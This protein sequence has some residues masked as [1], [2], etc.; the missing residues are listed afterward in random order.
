METI[1]SLREGCKIS[2]DAEF[3]LNVENIDVFLYTKNEGLY[4]LDDDTI[5]L[6]L[7]K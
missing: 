2:E 7:S 4:Q 6:I 5:S 3:K 1:N